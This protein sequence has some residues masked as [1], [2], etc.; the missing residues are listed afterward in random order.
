MIC[1]CP[2]CVQYPAPTYTEEWRLACL[3][4][5]VT[6][7]AKDICGLP[8]RGRRLDALNELPT[9][10]QERVRIAVMEQWGKA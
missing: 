10:L 5:W 7:K 4:R 6:N 3:S 9:K 8:S 1:Q 2:M